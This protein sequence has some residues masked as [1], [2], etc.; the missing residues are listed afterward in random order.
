MRM[1]GIEYFKTF[2]NVPVNVTCFG[3]SDHHQAIKHIV[4]SISV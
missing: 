3:H 4:Y 1:H 2:I